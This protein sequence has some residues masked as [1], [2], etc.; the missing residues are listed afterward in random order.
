[1]KKVL[2]LGLALAL[3]SGAAYANFC[4]KD[5]VPAATLL[6]PYAV[7]DLNP[8]LITPNPAGYTTLLAVT[9]VSSGAALIHVTVWSAMSNPVVDFDEVLSGYDVWS[10]N[11]RDLL[12]GRFDLFDTEFDNPAWPAA[13][14]P[15]NSYGPTTNQASGTSGTT[16]TL[17]APEE[18]SS[19]FSPTTCNFPYGN[20][21]SLGPVIV[22]NLKNDIHGGYTEYISCQTVTTSTPPWLA[23]LGKAPVF[24]YVT[25]DNV[26]KCST[27]F[28]NDSTYF[29]T[30][31]PSNNNQLIGDIVYLNSTGN[32]SESI[33]AT[34]L[35]AN[36]NQTEFTG[37]TFYGRYDTAPGA[38]FDT[39]EPLGT[40]YAFRYVNANGVSSSLRIWKNAHEVDTVHAEYLACLPYIYFAWDEDE[41]SLVQTGG[42]SG[43]GTTQPNVIPFETQE[44]PLNAA[45][46]NGIPA[47]N[48]WMM[49]I[50]DPSLPNAGNQDPFKYQADAAV[51]YNL[52]GYSTETPAALIG[53]VWCFSVDVLGDQLNADGPF[54]RTWWDGPHYN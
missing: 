51:K 10:I 36:A 34:S 44:A 23:T 4:A 52:G 2:L 37:T 21:S 7:V 19:S 26:T 50:F 18:P 33:Q 47:L 22:T 41:N 24:F 3:V 6:V 42:P 32:F 43:F 8:D 14:N 20:L 5:Y 54:A 29:S 30:G 40:A 39:R 53:N 49:L 38:P 35:E 17:P 12:N 16:Y 1:M 46:W 28:P 31:I 48:G 11:F 27:K 13:S 15:V 9:N 25:I 45:N